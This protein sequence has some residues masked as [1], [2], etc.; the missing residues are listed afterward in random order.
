MI[1]PRTN[2]RLRGRN[3]SIKPAVLVID[4]ERDLGELL[5]DLLS[6]EFEVSYLIDPRQTLDQL[7]QSHYAC[8]LTDLSMPHMSGKELVEMVRVDFPQLPIVVM[9]GRT[10]S[11]PAVAE[12]LALGCAGILPKPLPFVEA[13]VEVIKKAI[14]TR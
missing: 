1:L 11:D 6:D 13:I 14:A 8:L 10:A 2:V 9:S 4:D 3:L 5:A 12:V 7:H